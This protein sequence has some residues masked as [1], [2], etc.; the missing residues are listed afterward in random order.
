MDLSTKIKKTTNYKSQIDNQL[1]Q[2]LTQLNK[3]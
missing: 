3:I 2:K 1:K